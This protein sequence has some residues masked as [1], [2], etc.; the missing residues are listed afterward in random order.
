MSTLATPDPATKPTPLVELYKK[1]D[2]LGNIPVFHD[3]IGDYAQ[4]TIEEPFLHF[5]L[6]THP[7]EI[8]HWFEAQNAEFVVGEVLQGIRQA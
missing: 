5:P 2:I 3:G 1:W 8:W 7:E 4:G 6:G